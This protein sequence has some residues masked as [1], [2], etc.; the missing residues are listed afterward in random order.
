MKIFTKF[1]DL[2]IKLFDFVGMMIFSI[3]EIPNKLRNVDT[4][5]I[6]SKMNTEGIKENISKFKDDNISNKISKVSQKESYTSINEK[7]E[8]KDISNSKVQV[9]EN[10]TS[11]EKERTILQLQ[12]LSGAF[13][14]ISILYIFNFLSF[15]IYGILGVLLVAYFLYLLF[16]KVKLMYSEDFNAYRDFFL[17]YIA[18]GI[19]LVLISYNQDLVMAFSFSFLPSAS[20]LIF[21]VILVA[22]IFLIFRI[23]YHRNYTYGRV[24]E[25]GKKTAYVKVD[26]DI[27]S[28]VKPD[29][30]LVENK[31]NAAEEDKVKLQIE[32]KLFNTGGN[33]PISII[34]TIE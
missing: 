26:Y 5:N 11:E 20:I 17:M 9:S 25:A 15:S 24:I 33:K 16:N 7:I 2:I 8:Y 23:R 10:F 6:K 14:V 21:A 18:A 22:A 12:I 29:I 30:Y 28:N 27:R 13:L 1:G 3:S 32:E 4:I 19:I 34:M 31:V